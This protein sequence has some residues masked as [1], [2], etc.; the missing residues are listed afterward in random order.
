MKAFISYR[1]SNEPV[2]RLELLLSAACNGL[3]DANIDQF[4]LFFEKKKGVIPQKSQSDMMNIAFEQITKSDFLFVLQASECHSEGVLMEVGYAIAKSIPVIVATHSSVKMTYLPDMADK[5]IK[6]INNEDLR[7]QIGLIN[8]AE[9][10]S[11]NSL[12]ARYF[13]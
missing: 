10:E 9:F 2:E 11:T 13:M 5:K 1:Y 4:C 6:Y 7:N 8:F 3:Q 12:L